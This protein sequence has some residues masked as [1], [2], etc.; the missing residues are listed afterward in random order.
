M[1]GS[2][3]AEVLTSTV[4]PRARRGGPGAL[5][6]GFLGAFTL[7]VGL[8]GGLGW[9]YALRQV[10]WFG[11][12]PKVN[13]SLPLL[14][15]AQFDAQPLLRVV[16]AWLAAGLVAGLVLGRV[17]RLPRALMAAA[18]GAVLLFLDAQA[19]YA[20][21]RNLRFGDVVWSHDPA[22]GPW[23]AAGLFALGCALPRSRPG[24][25]RRP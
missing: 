6:R 16:V 22:L 15:L 21:A 7:L 3:Y 13:D 4:P 18:L 24:I 12:G 9:C 19:S 2:E 25:D 14:Q 5:A 11:A 17:R 23:L 8:V 20:L 10:G 1:P